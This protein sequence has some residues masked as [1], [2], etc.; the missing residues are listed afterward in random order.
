MTTQEYERTYW[1]Y[2]LN[3][4][5]DFLNTE[6]YVA[7]DNDNKNTFS[8]EYMKILQM[9]CA[10]VEVVAKM[11]CE[12]LS[13]NT[14]CKNIIDYCEIISDKLLDFSENDVF[15]VLNNINIKP[16]SG[17]QYANYVDEKKK[18]IASPSWWKDYNGVKHNRIGMVD[19]MYYYKKANQNNV[20]YALAALFQVEMY[21]YNLLA[22]NENLERKTPL[23]KS[24]LFS[25]PRWTNT[26][27]EGNEI[28]I[29]VQGTTMNIETK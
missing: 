26:V 2:Y 23:P 17:W 15:F 1:K 3:L 27:S 7:I 20:I 28:L 5:N 19:G 10:E 21:F 13:G 4:E 8:I 29:T 25:I 16:W 22:D 9:V 14:N 11:L 6:K 12:D 24:K 18:N